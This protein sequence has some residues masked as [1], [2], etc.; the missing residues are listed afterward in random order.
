[1]PLKKYLDRYDPRAHPGAQELPRH[2][3]GQARAAP[4]RIGD[5]GRGH[6]G[7]LPPEPRALL[8]LYRAAGRADRAACSTRS[9]K[10]ARPTTPWWSSPP[11]TATWWARTACGSRAGFPTRSATACRWWC[12]GP[13]MVKAGSS[14]IAPGAAPRP[15]AHLRAG[16]RRGKAMPYA[17]GRATA[18]AVRRPRARGLGRRDPVRLLRR[19][20]P[21]HAAHRHQRTATS[22]S[23]TASTIDELYDLREDP[24]R[25]AQ[26][27]GATRSTARRPTTCARGCTS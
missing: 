14:T 23:S 24:E 15:G 13:G 26:R 19:R 22:T 17:D 6:R 20:V 1:M 21:L 12:A 10:P 18:A 8:R 11:T 25:D 2:L 16:G 9:M 7:R 4:A 27:G 3:R 5:L